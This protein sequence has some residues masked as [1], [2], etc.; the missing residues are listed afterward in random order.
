MSHAR[1]FAIVTGASTGIGFELAKRCS[2]A[3]CPYR[4]NKP[5]GRSLLIVVVGLDCTRYVVDGFERGCD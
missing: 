1:S 4:Y 3:A 5:S 2:I